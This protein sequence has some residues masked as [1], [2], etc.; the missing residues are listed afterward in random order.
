[1]DRGVGILANTCIIN[2][3]GKEI[4]IKIQ[5]FSIKVDES[6]TQR[7]YTCNIWNKNLIL[8]IVTDYNY[9][10][11]IF[12]MPEYTDRAFPITLYNA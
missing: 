7:M 1:M 9:V 6:Q 8:S 11:W 3:Q 4:T 12:N 5:P 10:Q 2:C